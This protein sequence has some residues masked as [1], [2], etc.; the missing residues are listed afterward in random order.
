MTP[1]ILEKESL[2]SANILVVDDNPANLRLLAEILKERGNKIRLVKDSKIAI[3]SA[4]VER[5]DLILLDIMMPEVDGYEVCSQLKANPK[6]RNIPVIFLSAKGEV[7]D[8]VKGFSLGAVDYITKPFAAEEVVAR[9]ENHLKI[10]QLSQE[11]R[12]QNKLLEE[13]VR[14]RVLAE[15]TLRQREGELRTLVENAP[16][17]ILRLDRQYRYLYVNPKFTRKLGK[18]R[19][20]ILGKTIRELNTID[21]L[22]ASWEQA[23]AEV[24]NTGEEREIELEIPSWGEIR[25][26]SARLVPE[27]GKNGE[28]E[29]VLAIVRDF[30][31]R[32]LAD[33]E[34]ERLLE[35]E[36]A[37]KE[38][39]EAARTRAT[40]IL[41]SIGD[42]FFALDRDWKF[43]YVN[44]QAEV[45]LRRK[46]SELMGQ[47]LW[48]KFPEALG[49]RFEREYR[50]V[51]SQQLKRE[52]V[53]FY[54]PLDA[55]F[56][57][58]AFPGKEGILVY[59]QDVGDRISAETALRN[60]EHFLRSIYEGV[61]TAIFIIEVAENGE[62][63][64][65]GLNPAHE[66]KSGI[67]DS[68]LKGKTP[69]E[70]LPPAA[71]KQVSDRYHACLA[72]RERIE[73]EECLSFQGKDT[74][75]ITKLTPLF[76]SK[77]RI[78][79]LIGTSFNITDRKEAELA[80]ARQ[81]LREQ[82]VT[83]IQDRIRSSLNLEEILTTATEEIRRFLKSDRVLIYQIL[84]GN[85][86]I[87]IIESV[88]PDLTSICDQIFPEQEFPQENYDLYSEGEIFVVEDI[89]TAQISPGQAQFLKQSGIKAKLGIP[90]LKNREL[91]G[92]I[93]VHQCRQVRR[94]QAAELESLKQIAVQVAIGIQ[95]STLYEQAQTEIK[96]RE[97]AEIALRKSQRFVEQIADTSPNLL[98]IFDLEE[99]RNIYSNREIAKIL[100]YTAPEIREMGNNILPIIIHPH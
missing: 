93:A 9:I 48:A 83:T 37:A 74:W 33:L 24:F 47:S 79:R 82:L 50:L 35:R 19:A 41:E 4:L 12:E 42:A 62:F 95:Q 14:Q 69:E 54:P 17:A 21:G 57:V 64:Y 7:F 63:R 88:A 59:F 22:T 15:T 53:E 30:S 39:A 16:D 5:P 13:E 1:E 28:V 18:S 27:W 85:V 45:L 71:A 89:N 23:V 92:L 99:Q 75:W 8:K 29:T 49:S 11:L 70:V 6:T 73:Y 90:I 86:R 51:V 20:E 32:K 31:D 55:W 100:G 40:D 43:T 78:Y 52:F 46:R 96:E 60:S 65:V 61:E 77:N 97:T 34:R 87:A 58:R 3:Q 56:E 81:M 80:L 68:D 66:R 2:V 94:W 98:Y 38:E 67:K 10:W 84:S 44:R 91:W 26:Y 25:F 72:A 76:D 36:Q